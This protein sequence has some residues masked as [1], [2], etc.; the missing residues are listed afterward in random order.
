MRQLILQMQ[1]MAPRLTLFTL[2]G[3]DGTGKTLAARAL[4]ANGSAADGPFVPCLAS[5]FFTP[6]EGGG[7]ARW[8]TAALEQAHR[9]MLFL[10]RVHQLSPD[11][12]DMLAD[13]LRWFDH[14]PSQ[15]SQL[16]LGSQDG[17]PTPGTGLPAQVA[18]SSSIPLRKADPPSPFRQDVASRLYAVRFRLPALRERREDIPMLAQTLIQRFSRAYRKTVRGLGPGTIAPL[19][20]HGWPGNVRELDQ[21]ITAACLETTSQWIRPIDLPPFSSLIPQ[22]VPLNPGP[23]GTESTEEPSW[24]LDAVIRFHVHKVLQ[25]TRGNKLRAA[26]LLGVSRST[27]YRVLAAEPATFATPNHPS[28]TRNHGTE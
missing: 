21:V 10:D 20:R 7:G 11:Q 22:S 25:H 2:E 3:E 12:Q 5:R 19:L 27:L 24:N 16:E 8:S 9:G 18:F 4:H 6:S 13:F 1:R 23:R 14:Q 15:A 28:P 26:K 17:E